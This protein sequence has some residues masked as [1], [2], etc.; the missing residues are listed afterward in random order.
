MGEIIKRQGGEA[1]YEA[2]E[3]V[4]QTTVRLRQQFDAG[5]EKE[6]LEWIQTL[7]LDT[8]TYVIRAFT[9]YFQ[10]ANLA[11]EVH[12]LRR[13]RHYESLPDHAPQRGSL[14]EAALH[15]SARGVTPP[16]IQKFLDHLSIEIVLTA[17]PT[18]AQRQ[19]VLT[20]LLRIALLLIDHDRTRLTP[21][22][23][24]RFE[25]DVKLEIEAL[26]QTDE[27]RR[28]RPTPVDEA[29]NGLFYLDQVLFDGVPRTLEKLERRLNEFYGRKIHVPEIL[30]I[31]SWMGGDRDANPYVTHQITLDVAERT[32]SSRCANTSDAVDELI[33]RCSLSS[34]FAP[35]LPK[36][37]ASLKRDMRRF[38]AARPDDGGAFSARTVSPEAF[39]HEA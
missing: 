5:R 17:H 35:P 8:S 13:K 24:K 1:V 12:R 38:P 4:R 37:L 19:T 31:G 29:E 16:E 36:L 25:R 18:E 21:E 15:L 7:D 27:I 26:W 23:E 10:L 32:R 34:D 28:R 3:H 9:L 20:K 14:E 22:E 11:E 39:L 2:V 30:Q 6:L 33:G